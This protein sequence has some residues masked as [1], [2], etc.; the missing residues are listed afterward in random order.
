MGRIAITGVGGYLGACL[1]E[2]LAAEGVDV[3]GVDLRPP[4][5]ARPVAEFVRQDVSVPCDALFRGR[6]VDAVVHLA[7]LVA[8]RRDWAAARKV[9]VGGAEN[10]LRACA[11]AGV[12]Q[13]VYLSSTTVY[14]AHPDNP[15]P[16]T[17]GSPLR[18]VRGFQYG[19]HKAEAERLFQRFAAERPEARLAVLRGCV[20]LGPHADNFITRSFFQPVMLGVSGHDPPLQFVHEDDVAEVLLRVLSDEVRGVLNLAAPG[21]L[22]YSEV[23]RRA[24]RRLAWLPARLL[25]ALTDIT[26]RL[27]LQSQGT[28]AGLAFIRYPW[29]ASGEKL[30]RELGYTFRYGTPEAVAAFR[31][32]WTRAVRQEPQP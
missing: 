3:L 31:H 12:R 10:V 24:G 26:W 25:A 16:L 21:V 32:A 15:V 2:R 30:Q 28:S 14:G 4:P 7:F 22:S 1:L 18:P 9:N 20:V 13:V 27:R 8:P 17:E 29:V 5:V 19:W 11:A 23:A 6:S